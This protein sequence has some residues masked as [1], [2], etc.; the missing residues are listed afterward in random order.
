MRNLKAGA[1]NNA[2][3]WAELPAVS[4]IGRQ[5]AVL[6]VKQDVGFW[7]AFNKRH[8]FWQGL[9]GEPFSNA[10]VTDCMTNLHATAN[11]DMVIKLVMA[12]TSH[13]LYVTH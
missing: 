9:H 10:T 12:V 5:D 8:Q 1:S 6:R 3:V 4:R 11:F 7:Q 2:M 13:D